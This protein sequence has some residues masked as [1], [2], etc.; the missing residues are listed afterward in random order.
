MN[1]RWLSHMELFVIVGRN[2]RVIVK[3]AKCWGDLRSMKP[4][5]DSITILSDDGL[6]YPLPLLG[7]A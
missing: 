7:M 5:E 3:C 2:G 6:W 1:N 4:V